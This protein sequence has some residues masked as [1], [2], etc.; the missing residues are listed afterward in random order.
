MIDI[1]LYVRIDNPINR[2]K[3][4]AMS[5]EVTRLPT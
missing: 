2:Q 1:K 4:I 5:G 3:K